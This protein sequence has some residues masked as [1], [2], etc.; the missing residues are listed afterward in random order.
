[1]LML[2]IDYGFSIPYLTEPFGLSGGRHSEVG[3]ILGL[4]LLHYI[5][6]L[7]SVKSILLL[8]MHITYSS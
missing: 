8:L 5:K 7:P 2:D 6:D 4:Y 1:M 3:H